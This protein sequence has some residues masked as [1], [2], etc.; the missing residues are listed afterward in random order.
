MQFNPVP[1]SNVIEVVLQD[2]DA[3]QASRLLSTL[4]A[5]YLKKHAALQAGG[6]S[7]PEFFASQVKFH[8]EKF[9][10][11][12][13]ALEKFQEKDNIT[14][15]GSEIDLNLQK[16]ATM[17]A[18]LKEL[19]GEID[20]TA[21]E[22]TM[23]EG[24]VKEQPDEITKE[25]RVMV[26]PE[27]TGII[28]KL[29]ELQRQ[30]EEL[31]Q[32]YQPGS[33]FVRDK[34]AEIAAAKAAMAARD[35]NIVGETTYAQNRVKENVVQQ[36][37]TKRVALEALTAKKKSLLNEKKAYDARLEVLKDRS[38]DLA[39]LRGNFDLTRDNYFMYEKK[40]EEARVSRAMDEE[41]I[42]NAGIVQEAT[43]P[44]IPLPRGLLIWGPLAAAAGAIL[45]AALALVLEFFSLT[46]KDER[47]IEQ[48]LQVPVLATV[49]HF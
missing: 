46:I 6:D 49:R 39:R 2:P 28:G 31:L 36:L 11:A 14:N 26:N 10:Q 25:S 16:L 12:R 13:E 34:D 8:R 37:L 24:Q 32:R 5:L 38:F 17:E 20:S 43:P 45:G 15:I 29:V 7:T 27:I 35:Q 18:T 48:F 47:D 42:A 19:Q 30:R 3:R 4:A 22:V 23:L 1:D 41:N 21:R 9:D 40:A 33:R 44:V